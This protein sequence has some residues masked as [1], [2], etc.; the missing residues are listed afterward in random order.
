VSIPVYA[1]NL[2]NG[3]KT[4]PEGRDAPHIK[5]PPLGIRDAPGATTQRGG[6]F[7]N[8]RADNPENKRRLKAVEAARDDCADAD[9][10]AYLSGHETGWNT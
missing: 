4:E 8:A 7:W 1:V 3:Q 6:G 2:L 9:S 10:I 5:T